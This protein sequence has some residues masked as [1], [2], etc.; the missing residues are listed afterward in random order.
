MNIG[1]RLTF[2]N[3]LRK[4]G[5]EIVLHTASRQIRMDASEYPTAI[6]LELL[7]NLQMASFMVEAR[8]IDRLGNIVRRHF[9]EE[10]VLSSDH[11]KQA[12][13]EAFTLLV[14]CSRC[15]AMMFRYKLLLVSHRTAKKLAACHLSLGPSPGLGPIALFPRAS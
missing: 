9:D 3:H 10:D 2:R 8:E 4:N 1:E 15:V 11:Q 14:E 13:I 7:E 12:W 5:A 6:N